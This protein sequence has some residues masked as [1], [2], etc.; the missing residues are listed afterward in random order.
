MATETQTIPPAHSAPVQKFSR[1]RSVRQAAAQP[2]MPPPATQASS[3]T[4]NESIL[5]SASRYRKRSS[6]SDPVNSPPPPQH[7]L[8]P[9]R[10]PQ[11]HSA[12][13][14]ALTGETY[15]EDQELL[16][17]PPCRAAASRPR[18][19]S[20]SKNVTS[21]TKNIT[22][23]SRPSTRHAR[24]IEE[25]QQPQQVSWEEICAA[26]ARRQ[27]P[28]SPA[29]QAAGEI[30]V[31]EDERTQQLKVQPAAER[32]A[33]VGR[34]RA[35]MAGEHQRQ[36]RAQAGQHERHEAEYKCWEQ[37]RW[38]LKQKHEEQQQ[39]ASERAAAAAK[40]EFLDPGRGNSIRQKLGSF[41]RT[42]SSEPLGNDKTEKLPG[43]QKLSESRRPHGTIQK[44]RP[45]SDVPISKP[46]PSNDVST[47]PWVD[48]PVSKPPTEPPV[49]AGPARWADAPVNRP[50]KSNDAPVLLPQYD[51]PVSAVNAGERHVVIRCNDSSITLPITPTTTPRDLINSASSALPESID[52][53]RSKLV[54]TFTQLGLERPLRNYEHVRDVMNSWDY[55]AQYSFVI[56]PMADDDQNDGLD[57]GNAPKQQPGDTSIY[58]C[59][60]QRPGTWGKR[61]ITLRP[62]GQ[63]TIA[64][65]QG[66]ETTN[67]CHLTDFDVYMPT[68][69]QQTRR[70]RPPKKICYAVKSLQKS[71]VFLNGANFVHFFAT[72]DLVAAQEWYKAVH[73]WRSW[74]L[75]NVLGDGQK[76]KRA[77][78]TDGSIRPTTA[79]S[80]RASIDGAPHQLG[81]FR[82]LLNFEDDDP[83]TNNSSAASRATKSADVFHARKMSGR[84]RAAPPSAFLNKLS[85]DEPSTPTTT[86]QTLPSL[87][88]GPTPDEVEGP[89]FVP[90]GPLGRTHSQRQRAQRERDVNGGRNDSMR[91]VDPPTGL[92]RK[93]ST[94]SVRQIP[95]PLIDLTPQYQEPPQHVRKGRGVNLEPGQQLVDAAT[96]LDLPPG[97]VI[98]PSANAWR[99]P[100]V[101]SPPHEIVSRPSRQSMDTGRRRASIDGGVPTLSMAAGRPQLNNSEAFIEGGLLA[102]IS[103]KRAQGGSGTGH[104]VRTGDRSAKGKPMIELQMKSQFAD[105]SLLRQV[106]A[107][108]SGDGPIIDRAKRYEER[109]RR[110]EGEERRG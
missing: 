75:A 37:P 85:K 1:Y 34:R 80:R 41:T 52:P 56:L 29:H 88:K 97:A 98:P 108:A 45:I 102:R 4:Q 42:K 46:A 51:A 49:D 93:T 95:K 25:T 83:S 109:V 2:Q 55:D 92:T 36:E 47:A 20:S 66:Q 89:I 19:H 82:P 65:R 70:I 105:G 62:D 5:P 39:A 71:N 96:G 110:G 40:E 100:Q 32:E 43:K 26:R 106:E 84:D 104:G 10:I 57:L 58:M 86:N 91:S 103:S 6:K 16:S 21:P 22:S 72:N 69:R 27:S 107:H 9:A 81:S 15:A 99:R 48:A 54:E 12:S 30:L 73:G 17:S 60:S 61:W 87:V 68:H 94:K 50:T 76:R 33:K 101:Q 31:A 11:S 44:T 8:R 13:L 90:K 18:Q 35:A 53:S 77:S 3:T 59:H 38:D 14:A 7:A 24:P 64:K 23:R 28:P 63:M 79:R 67:I 74:Y 78:T